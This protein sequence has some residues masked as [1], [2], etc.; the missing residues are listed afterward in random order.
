MMAAL[1]VPEELPSREQL[2]SITK[3]IG[4]SWKPVR[5]LPPDWIM[6]SLALGIFLAFSVIAATAVGFQGFHHLTVYQR[7]FYYAVLLLCAFL[8]SVLTVGEMIPGSRK[9]PSSSAVIVAAFF[10]VALVAFA[11]F[12]D[13][14]LEDFADR[15]LPCLRIGSLCAAVSGVVAYFFLRKG[16]AHSPLELCATAGFFA[17]LAG[18]A[19]LALFCPFQN[20]P[21]ILVWHLGAML[22]G[23]LGGV[24]IGLCRQ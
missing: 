14:S 9:R 12:H 5:P 16:L 17:G 8:F 23:G 7:L 20:I 24:L 15:G 18:V 2:D 3:I 10:S 22:A 21:H 13:F 11:L 19:V 1:R 6:I 4:G